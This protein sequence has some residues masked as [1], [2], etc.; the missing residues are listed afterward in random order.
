MFIIQKV[1]RRDAIQHL[2]STFFQEILADFS[3]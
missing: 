2:L 1:E 3:T